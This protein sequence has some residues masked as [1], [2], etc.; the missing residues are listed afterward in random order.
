MLTL[1]FDLIYYHCLSAAL[2]AYYVL[3]HPAARILHVEQVLNCVIHTRQL[4]TVFSTNGQK[5][6]AYLC[7]SEQF[8]VS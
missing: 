7:C 3:R 1:E 8:D 6:I 4:C 5:G 2:A